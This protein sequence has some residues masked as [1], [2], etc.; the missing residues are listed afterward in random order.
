M[1]S[2]FR[3]G[4]NVTQPFGV[5]GLVCS[6]VTHM[7]GVCRK[8]HEVLR[9]VVKR[10]AVD[11][12]N[13][14]CRLQ[15]STE[16]LF[17]DIAVFTDPA[18]LRGE[19]MTRH[20]NVVIPADSLPSRLLA[21]VFAVPR[22]EGGTRPARW[23]ITELHLADCANTFRAAIMSFRGVELIPAGARAKTL[24][25]SSHKGLLTERADPRYQSIHTEFT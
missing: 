4:H 23:I 14:L 5:N 1:R 21:Y 6:V 19:G 11:M 16:L 25:R 17:H 22:A 2:P 13:H 9:A 15:V 20:A 7:V 12:M 8:Q 3:S 24:C 18:F 10:I